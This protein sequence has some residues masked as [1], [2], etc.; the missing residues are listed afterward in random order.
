[1]RGQIQ[2]DMAIGEVE[3]AVLHS[4]KR[5]QYRNG[6]LIGPEIAIFSY[7][8]ELIF[9]EKLQIAVAMGEG[10]TRMKDYYDLFKLARSGLDK[11]FLRSCLEAVFTK[12]KTQMVSEFVLDHRELANL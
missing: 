11:D 10:N 12:R 7:P 1:M 2:I 8:R 3:K 6:P 5:M 4:I 9:A